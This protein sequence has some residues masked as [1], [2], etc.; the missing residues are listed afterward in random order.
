MTG[1]RT[2]LLAASAGESDAVLAK[3]ITIGTSVALRLVWP[4]QARR[5]VSH[6]CAHGTTT[7]LLG[8]RI[9]SP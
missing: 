9:W 7:P 6:P 4:R 2:R 1:P 8:G 5:N 3:R